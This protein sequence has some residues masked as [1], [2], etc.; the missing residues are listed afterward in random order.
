[1]VQ[2]L[3]F[4]DKKSLR[5]FIV[6]NFRKRYATQLGSY[7]RAKIFYK[8][9]TPWGGSKIHVVTKISDIKISCGIK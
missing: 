2:V 1:M 5:L 6:Y 7:Q 8:H 9:L 4:Q 3:S